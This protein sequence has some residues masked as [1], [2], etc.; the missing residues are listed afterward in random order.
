MPQRFE[1][2]GCGRLRLNTSLPIRKGLFLI[3]EKYVFDRNQPQPD[4]R[5]YY[6][7][8]KLEMS[9]FTWTLAKLVIV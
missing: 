5:K 9:Y 3:F 6:K 4:T 2:L 8:S 7:R 1:V